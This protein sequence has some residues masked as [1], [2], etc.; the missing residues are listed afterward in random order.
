[1]GLRT[2]GN[3]LARQP[4][5]CVRLPFYTLILGVFGIGGNPIS[6]RRKTEW[7]QADPEEE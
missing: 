5:H 2:L 7:R 6:S 3:V 4:V 1:M